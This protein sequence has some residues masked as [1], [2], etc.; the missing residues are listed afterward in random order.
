MRIKARYRVLLIVLAAIVVLA[1]GGVV[2]V[3]G[4]WWFPMLQSLE[5]AKK[6]DLAKVDIKGTEWTLETLLSD[7][8]ITKTESLLLVNT[9][10]LLPEGYT[11]TLTE[12]NSAKMNPVMVE[13]YIRMRDEIQART[14]V[15]IYVAADYRTAEEQAEILASSDPGIAAPVGGSEHQTGLA[16]DVYAPRADGFQF[17]RSRAGR[18]VNRTCS[19]Y[20]FII[21]YPKGKEDVTGISYEPWHLRYVGAPHAE[22][23]AKS[24]L[25]LEEY[26][27]LLVPEVWFSSGEYLILRTE[28]KTVTLPEQFIEGEISPCFDGYYIITLKIK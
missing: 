25:T 3:H 21:R 6:P 17:L 13:H 12:Y 28:K 4:E 26:I 19:D 7:S 16:L 20:G 9:E 8:R 15:R 27:D 22:I 2:Y 5:S 11:A 10:H 23:I 1:G 14:G 24:K 18:E